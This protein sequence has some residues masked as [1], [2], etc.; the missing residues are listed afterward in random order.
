MKKIIKIVF[1]G[2][3]F[4]FTSFAQAVDFPVLLENARQGDVNAMCDVGLAYFNGQGTLK[5]PFKAKCWI[6]KAYNLKSERAAKIWEKLELWSFSGKCDISFDDY[7]LSRYKNGDVFIEP[8]T[9]IRF[10]YLS[11]GCFEMGCHEKA[12]KC[13]KEEK[14][15]HKVCLDGFWIGACEVDQTLWRKIMKNN[16]FR[17]S[18]NPLNPVENVS[19]D[20]VILFIQKLNSLSK[21]KFFLPT[22]AQWE[23]ACRNGGQPVNYPWEEDVGKRPD[24]NC[25]DCDSGTYK[26][27][28]SPCASFQPNDTGLYD[29]GGNVKEWC[30]DA[31]DKKAYAI[32][33]QMNPVHKKRSSTK[34]I[35]GG[36]YLDTSNK[37][38]CSARDKSI[39]SVRADYIGFRLV[40]KKTE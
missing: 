40:M 39:P 17:F 3:L 27:R 24:A 20:Q 7:V 29:M 37:L 1:I 38:R 16:P 31:Y 6:Q 19:Y 15:G 36:S 10:V 11:K 33:D 22:E 13:R 14:P 2:I 28:T 30:R 18:S 12:V 21:H 23:Y 34:V 8:F 4:F 32:H 26:G 35:R 5:D 25:G 9:G